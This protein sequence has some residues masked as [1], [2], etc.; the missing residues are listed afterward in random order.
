MPETVCAINIGPRERARRRATGAIMFVVGVT[1]AIILLSTDTS[2]WWRMA[3][4]IPFWLSMLG[5]F[6]ARAKT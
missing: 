6:Q 2:R 3:L 1:A 5:F 4:I